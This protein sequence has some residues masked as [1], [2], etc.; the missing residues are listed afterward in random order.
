MKDITTLKVE[1]P[2]LDWLNS[3]K[4]LMEW[5]HA[6][7]YTLNN[8][9]ITILVDFDIRYAI[10]EGQVKGS[11]VEGI[12]KYLNKRLRQFWG[13]GKLPDVAWGDLSRLLN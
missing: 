2:V 13:D 7:K 3:I 1:K 6:K 5:K 11:D 12:K 4:G 8:A 9:L 10:Q